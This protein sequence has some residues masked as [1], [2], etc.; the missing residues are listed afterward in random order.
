[1]DL[2]VLRWL[3]PTL[4]VVNWSSLFQERQSLVH[5]PDDLV[6]RSEVAHG[7][8]SVGVADPQSG[9]FQLERPF[10]KR[11]SLV[12][13]PDRPVARCEVTHG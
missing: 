12:H 6:G 7:H 11:Q 3:A 8:E 5:L 4:A 13:L 10:Q 9:S 2:S 1:M